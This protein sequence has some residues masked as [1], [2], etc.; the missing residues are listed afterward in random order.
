MTEKLSGTIEA[1]VFSQPE[2]GF[3]VARLKEGRKKD[4]TV[5][6][7]YLP[8]LQPGESVSCDGEW[9]NHPSHGR[10]FEVA[11]YTVESPSDLV[12]IQKY[13]ESGLVKGIGPVYAKK[14]VDRFG[15]D[16]LEVIDKAPYRLLEIQ[17]L[18]EKKLEKVKECWHQQRAIRE[19]MVFLR[20]F[21]ASPGFAQ[22]IYKAYGD[23][24]IEKVKENPYQLAKE[25]FGI[26]FK[27]A[28]GIA[29]KLGFQLHSPERLKAG[30]EFVLWELTGDG[31]T[32]YPAVDFL[33]IAK[34]ILEVDAALIE[35]QLKVL[36]EKDFL[37]EQE[38][39]IWLKVYFAYEQGISRDLLRL[40]TSAQAIRPIDAEKAAAWAQTQLSIQFAEQQKEAVIKALTDKVHIITGGPGTGKSTI[41]NA[42]L[43]V[44][45]K[46]TEKI[47]LAAPTGRAA[48]RMTQITKKMAFTIHSLLE[49]DFTSGGFKR[50]RDNPLDCDL[51]IIDEA[52]MIDTQ[53]LFSLLRAVPSSA[54][55]LFV[56]DIDQLPSVGAGTVLRD[57]ISSGLIGVTRLTEIFRQ[58]K[59]SKII[60]NAHLINEGEFPE[61][62][63]HERSDFHFIEAE[64][65]EAIQ[66]V[67]LRLVSTEIPKL[68]R[69]DPVDQIQVLSPMKRG[70]I[71]AEM[72]NDALQN[73]LN[74]SERPVYRSG[75][76]FH[77]SDKVMQLK[78]N[79]DK[80]VYNG[81]IG[82]IL[83]IDA[84]EQFLVVSFDDKQIEYEFSELDELILAY[85]TSVHKY[86][87]S[88]CPCVVI[89]I[90]TSH[91]KL[92]HR[93]LLY[94][95]VTR[96]K[97]QVYLVGTKK[98]IGIAVN[99]NQVQKR[100]TGL[101]KALRQMAKT[102]RPS[103]THQQ[104]DLL[105][106][107]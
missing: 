82:R 4:F 35:T 70:L 45:S 85:A 18:G 3:T 98:A 16:T 105:K 49:M 106:S 30:I 17:G 29:Q 2:N 83:E 22:K 34:E 1:I 11:E 84:T 24:S 55:V 66:Q 57:L 101:E 36:T 76:R 103:A 25:V 62:S 100:Y 54:R 42:I 58:A 12:G 73:L 77:V 52:S 46:L 5:I 15:T 40:N 59:G 67:I 50:G 80:K 87:G 60:T 21:G 10:Q 78:N 48:K 39:M 8:G 90:H 69:F 44:A 23:K 51:L 38:G 65:P 26:G 20:T 71:G 9:K 32:C 75:R 99:N 72:L 102:Y 89:P 37:V 19:V 56:G 31:H 27:I 64:T 43:A 13:L 93:N 107:T 33:P 14:I 91:F 97:K 92:L 61:I 96:G 74:P 86:Q 95:A 68:W 53:L 41:T 104:L 88:E 47:T 94:T 79:Y 63:T 7:G 28:D 6:V 81:D